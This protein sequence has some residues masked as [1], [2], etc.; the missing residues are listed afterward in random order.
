MIWQDV[1][2]AIVNIL[3]SY[4]LIPQVYKGFKHKKG[5]VVLLPMRLIGFPR[6]LR[7]WKTARLLPVSIAF[8]VLLEA[9]RA[10][11]GP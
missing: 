1:V 3:F 9:A 5:F 10:V 11:K 4:A 8:P 7:I 6:V 2:I